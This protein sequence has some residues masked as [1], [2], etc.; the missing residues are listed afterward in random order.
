MERETAVA[1][2]R[3][4]DAE[5]AI[6][7]ELKDMTTAECTGTTTRKPKTMFEEMLTAIGNSLSNLA[8]SDNEQDGED[9]EDDKED[10]ELGK[11]SHNDEP[12]CRLGTISKTEQHRMKSFRQKQMRLDE[13]AQP[14]LGDT[15]NYF[16]ERDMMYGTA[17]LKVPAVVKHQIDTTAATPPPTAFGEHMQTLDIIRGQSQMPAVTSRP[18]SSQMRLRSENPQ[19]HQFLLV[20]P[21]RRAPDLTL[22]QDLKPVEPISIYPCMKHP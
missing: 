5:T 1:R 7:Q 17:E 13:L 2:K 8:S 12:D 3:V 19:L 14:G 18:G 6:M 20:R 15:A 4:Q 16:H 9:E 21:P 10:T 11:L 22:I